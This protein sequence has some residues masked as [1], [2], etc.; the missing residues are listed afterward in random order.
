MH[1]I[2]GFVN[3]WVDTYMHAHG[4]NENDLLHQTSFPNSSNL[5]VLCKQLAVTGCSSFGAW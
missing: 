3:K 2:D 1:A 5:E 4:W